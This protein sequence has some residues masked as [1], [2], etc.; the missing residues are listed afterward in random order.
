MRSSLF[1]GVQAFRPCTQGRV[2]IFTHCWLGVAEII[3]EVSC[4]YLPVVFLDGC[5][6]F[7]VK[8]V[9]RSE[10]VEECFPFCSWECA[11]KPE[12]ICLAR[13]TC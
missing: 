11:G 6:G 2:L 5:L 7:D 4:K 3:L 12:A 13:I 1:T 8:T 10:Q 9:F